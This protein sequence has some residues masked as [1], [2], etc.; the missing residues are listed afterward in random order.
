MRY[1]ILITKLLDA[2][3]KYKDLGVNLSER[4]NLRYSSDIIR[5]MLM[6]IVCD[7]RFQFLIGKGSNWSY[8]TKV[9]LED[10]ARRLEQNMPC[11]ETVALKLTE[12]FLQQWFVEKIKALQL[13]NNERIPLACKKENIS[14]SKEQVYDILSS[15]GFGECE[16]PEMESESENEEIDAIGSREGD[17]ADMESEFE[18][19]LNNE[20]KQKPEKPDSKE[21]TKKQIGKTDSLY[22]QNV[23]TRF[24][25]KIPAS[26]FHLAKLI[27]RTQQ[28]AS[29]KTGKFLTA[30]KSDIAGISI[31]NDLSCLLPS[32]LALLSEDKTRDIFYRNF[33]N[34]QLQ[35]FASASSYQTPCNKHQDGPI[36][37]CLDTSS[38]MYGEPIAVAKMLAIAV[39]IIAKRKNRPVLL[40]A[41]SYSYRM[42]E[43]SDFAMQK[44]E[45][46][47][48]LRTLDQSGNDENRMFRWLLNSYLP[49]QPTYKTADVLCISDFGWTEIHKDV[50]DSINKEKEKGCIFYGLNI[51]HE[52]YDLSNNKSQIITSLISPMDVLDSIWVYELGVCRCIKQTPNKK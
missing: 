51:G 16:K 34:K 14:M 40:V 41:Y 23:E 22:F 43:I 45:I 26:L 46:L 3:I 36:I 27:G 11:T 12:D 4:L 47:D 8:K 25:K 1:T 52:F 6:Q 2:A 20:N 48:F 18:N 7:E 31:G 5:S 24:L 9:E 19:K 35:I 50:M 39:M 17:K 28:E 29:Y 30:S 21:N 37:I 44:K 42:M 10:F 32:E 15:I 49:S 38:S 33:A 13:D